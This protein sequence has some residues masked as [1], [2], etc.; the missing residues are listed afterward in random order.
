MKPS[1]DDIKTFVETFEKLVS[2]E[3]GQA[4]ARGY[5]EAQDRIKWCEEVSPKNI[6]ILAWL[7]RMYETKG[8]PQ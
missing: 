4:V 3:A 7:K 1:K 8:R 6:R 2:L 5:S